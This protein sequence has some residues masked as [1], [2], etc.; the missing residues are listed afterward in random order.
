M[1]P[2]EVDSEAFNDNDYR[3]VQLSGDIYTVSE[4]I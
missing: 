1:G 2:S 3:R 4:Y